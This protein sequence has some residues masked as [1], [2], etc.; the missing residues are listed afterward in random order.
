MESMSDVETLFTIAG[1]LKCHVCVGN[2][3][4]SDVAT[5]YNVKFLSQEFCVRCRKF[6][7]QKSRS[8]CSLGETGVG[9][10]HK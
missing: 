4:L 10:G 1:I 6:G 3:D 7:S 8:D 2:R 9:R 5:I